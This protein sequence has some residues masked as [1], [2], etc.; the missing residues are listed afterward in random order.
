MVEVVKTL[1]VILALL[2][3][4]AAYAWVDDATSSDMRIVKCLDKFETEHH[5][6]VV[7]ELNADNPDWK[8]MGQAFKKCHGERM[9][10]DELKHM[11]SYRW[12]HFF[13]WPPK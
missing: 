13:G 12:L 8:V 7:Q 4:T 1:I 10:D 3:P 9:T 2:A 11:E 6:A 5:A